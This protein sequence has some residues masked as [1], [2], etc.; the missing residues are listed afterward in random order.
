[1]WIPSSRVR[2]ALLVIFIG[3]RTERPNGPELLARVIASFR[4]TTRMPAGTCSVIT[5]GT[6]VYAVFGDGSIQEVIRGL[7]DSA[8]GCW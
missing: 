4:K 3:L 5:I 8:K 1:M 7:I 2:G 6:R